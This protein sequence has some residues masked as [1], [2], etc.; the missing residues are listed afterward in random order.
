MMSRVWRLFAG[1]ALVLSCGVTWVLSQ[2]PAAPLPAP[3][4]EPI[5]VALVPQEKH[6][7]HMIGRAG[8]SANGCH[9]QVGESSAKTGLDTWRSS[10]TIDMAKDP[11]T[12]A[13]AVLN[14]ELST[15]MMRRLNRVS[16][17]AV[18]PEEQKATHDYRCLACHSNPSLAE[19]VRAKVAIPQ[20]LLAEGVNCEACHGSAEKWQISHVSWT[21]PA[22]RAADFANGGMLELNDLGNRAVACAGCHIG[23]PADAEH[24]F[25]VRDMNHDMIAAGHPRL[26]FDSADRLQRLPAHWH[27]RD[28]ST[29]PGSPRKDYLLEAWSVGHA[30]VSEAWCSLSKDR[31]IRKN[32]WPELSESNCT[33]CHHDLT[34]SG[35]N[36]PE[37]WVRNRNGK[38][39]L[40]SAMPWTSR[41][42]VGEPDRKTRPKNIAVA[43]AQK[44]R[45]Y[46]AKVSASPLDREDAAAIDA[47]LHSL[48][49]ALGVT[50]FDTV[51]DVKR[52]A[53]DT[54]IRI[55]TL[56]ALLE[57]RH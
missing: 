27:E 32:P 34:S 6:A 31:E 33:Q 29:F 17:D 38:T 50:K 3:K 52:F 1:I 11:H 48:E 2:N 12:R 44:L 54:K 4:T 22:T 43:I 45:K 7:P 14:G 49:A 24:G 19:E 35:K 9:G 13:Y 8:C 53:S 47:S 25:A 51:W 5:A 40:E 18:L 55:Q 36:H 20:S 28:R 16:A 26:K 37:T 42:L 15:K 39:L 30:A 21:K 46:E 57:N 10:F 41:D 23:A 56:I